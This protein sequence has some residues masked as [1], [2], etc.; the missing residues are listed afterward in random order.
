MCRVGKKPETR[1]RARVFSLPEP[2]PSPTFNTRPIP[3]TRHATR[4]YPPGTRLGKI[5]W[6]FDYF[7]PKFQ[8]IWL[9]SPFFQNFWLLFSAK[10]SK[11]LT[12]FSQTL[13]FLTIFARFSK[14]LAIFAQ[15][16]RISR[17]FIVLKF[18]KVLKFFI[19]LKVYIWCLKFNLNDW[20]RIWICS[21]NL[22]QSRKA[23]NPIK[24]VLKDSNQIWGL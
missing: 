12:T 16:F 21:W 20:K 17:F 18:F 9:F 11:F 14:F 10:F 22:F 6:F 4:G 7:S 15:K 13:K 3:E 2:D 19:V 1:A 5:C 8:K 24:R 23:P